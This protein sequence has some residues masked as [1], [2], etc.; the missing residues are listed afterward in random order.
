MT[1]HRSRIRIALPQSRRALIVS[2]CVLLLA[3]IVLGWWFAWR[4]NASSYTTAQASISGARVAANA[5]SGSN[6]RD[7]AL[8][9]LN[10]ESISTIA[11]RSVF[12]QESIRTLAGSPAVA[13]DHVVGD[14]FNQHKQALIDYGKRI[15]DYAGSL[16][17]FVATA[18]SCNDM[19]ANLGAGITQDEFT[20]VS[21]ACRDRIANTPPAPD[22]TIDSIYQTYRT[23]TK[24]VIDAYKAYFAVQ[25]GDQAAITQASARVQEAITTAAAYIQSTS[26]KAPGFT[27]PTAGLDAIA[28]K[29]DSQKSVFFKW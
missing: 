23:H 22:K 28:K 25:T 13:H 21:Q 11:V 2:A 9:P 7:L 19:I 12:Y 1:S 5:F 6:L 10:R 16:L 29:L 4:P 3:T 24:K 27:A 18:E 8:A 15:D 20:S 26:I 17:I 14:V